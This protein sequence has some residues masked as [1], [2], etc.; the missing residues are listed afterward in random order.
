MG[1]ESIY[2]NMKTLVGKQIDDRLPFN[3]F[4]EK[5]DWDEVYGWIHNNM[6]Y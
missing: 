3:C 2:S 4:H 1:K 5:I 6:R